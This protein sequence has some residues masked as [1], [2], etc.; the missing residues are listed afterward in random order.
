MKLYKQ[1]YQ[2]N[3][4]KTTS[5]QSAIE[6]ESRASIIHS[7]NSNSYEIDRRTE[8]N[9]AQTENDSSEPFDIIDMYKR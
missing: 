8:Q 4:V 2:Q 1:L 3:P 6:T 9:N 7:I 5:V